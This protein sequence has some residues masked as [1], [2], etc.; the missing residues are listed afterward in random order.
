[1]SG[2]RQSGVAVKTHVEFPIENS[3]EDIVFSATY[4][5]IGKSVL[6]IHYSSSVDEGNL[7]N[8]PVVLGYNN[9]TC[10]PFKLGAV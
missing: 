7:I 5:M 4:E 2:K 1:M 3:Q 9:D 6:V 10:L 8:V